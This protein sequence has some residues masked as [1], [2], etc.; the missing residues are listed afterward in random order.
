MD[1]L[2]RTNQIS[3]QMSVPSTPLVPTF[4]SLAPAALSLD[5]DRLN[6]SST[7]PLSS[8]R[9]K[10]STSF[11]TDAP[12]TT[13]RRA[14]EDLRD[15][16]DK[17]IKATHGSPSSNHI[18]TTIPDLVDNSSLDPAFPAPAPPTASDYMNENSAIAVVQTGTATVQSSLERDTISKPDITVPGIPLEAIET[19]QQASSDLLKALVKKDAIDREKQL[20][21]A[22][23]T[24]RTCLEIEFAPHL[25][26]WKEGARNKTLV[27]L[28]IV[29]QESHSKSFR[30]PRTSSVSLTGIDADL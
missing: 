4:A 14:F 15:R 6:F 16:V 9:F 25:E 3:P 1:Q 8:A 22:V 12:S 11:T 18:T 17:R 26:I 27:N 21:V 30:P 19:L 2:T 29:P 13:K 23:G 7:I 10:S 5:P 20:M 24:I 28:D